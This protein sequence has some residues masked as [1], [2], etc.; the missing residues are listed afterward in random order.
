MTFSGLSRRAKRCAAEGP[1]SALRRSGKRRRAAGRGAAGVAQIER[2]F[3]AHGGGAAVPAAGSRNH[4]RQSCAVFLALFFV[5]PSEGNLKAVLL[6]ACVGLSFPG[7]VFLIVPCAGAEKP[8]RHAPWGW[9]MTSLRS[10][11]RV[12]EFVLRCRASAPHTAKRRT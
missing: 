1:Q 9:A 6:F 3:K 4:R 10:R 11:G 12:C 5:D 7:A 8:A 2:R